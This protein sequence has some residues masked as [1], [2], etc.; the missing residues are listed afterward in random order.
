MTYLCDKKWG[1]IFTH[2]STS[3]LL[4]FT[5]NVFKLF[6]KLSDIFMSCAQNISKDLSCLSAAHLYIVM[7]KF[8][9]QTMTLFFNIK[10]SFCFPGCNMFSVQCRIKPANQIIHTSTPL[11]YLLTLPPHGTSQLISGGKITSSV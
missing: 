3:L 4:S 9:H 8:A 5:A 6:L 11:K 1:V 7:S 2:L 10:I